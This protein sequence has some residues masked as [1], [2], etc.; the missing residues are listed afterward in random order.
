[1]LSCMLKIIKL[2]EIMLLAYTL[3]HIIIGM[4]NTEMIFER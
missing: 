2:C 3:Y 1:M 4:T